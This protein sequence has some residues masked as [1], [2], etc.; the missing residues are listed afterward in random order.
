[1][2]KIKVTNH[3]ITQFLQKDLGFFLEQELK[4]KARYLLIELAKKVNSAIES[5]NKVNEELIKKYGSE[6]EGGKIGIPQFTDD[7]K[8]ELTESFK[9][10]VQDLEPLLLEEQ[11]LEVKL[12][13]EE[14]IKDI[15]NKSSDVFFRFVKWEE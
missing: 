12:I 5:F 4:P 3:E 6:L 15:P 11:E 13:P 9:N 8:Q 10:Y 1:M 2:E 14:A 7:T